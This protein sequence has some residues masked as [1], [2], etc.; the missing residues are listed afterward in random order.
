MIIPLPY[1]IRTRA[2]F[3]PDL[4]IIL[5]TGVFDILHAEHEAFLRSA[6]QHG[7]ILLTGIETDARVTQ[8]KGPSRPVNWLEVRLQNLESL[9]LIDYVFSLPENF[10]NQV[11]YDRLMAD[12]HPDIYANSE[13]S[14]YLDNKRTLTEKYGGR[15]VIVHPHNP[16]ISTTKILEDQ[17]R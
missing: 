14:P 9:D 15:L 16:A 2:T 12:L 3:D 4:T 7:D 8:L 6:K 13:H 11:A 10:D 1:L 17:D 5:T